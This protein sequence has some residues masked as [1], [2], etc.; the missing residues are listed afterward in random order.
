M[1]EMNGQ[2]PEEEYQY[3]TEQESSAFLSG[4]SPAI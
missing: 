1:E 4:D 3:G 2:S